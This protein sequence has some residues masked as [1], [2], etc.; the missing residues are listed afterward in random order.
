MKD[1]ERRGGGAALHVCEC[2]SKLY[3]EKEES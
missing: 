2:V 1:R 3:I